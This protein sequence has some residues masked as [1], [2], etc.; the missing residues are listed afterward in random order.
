[1]SHARLRRHTGS[2]FFVLV[3]LGLA[4]CALAPTERGK[5]A[6]PEPSARPAI[7]AKNLVILQS[8]DSPAFAGVSRAIAAKV[9]G[10]VPVFSVRGNP[11]A[12]AKVARQLR[13]RDDQVVVAVGLDAA[14][15]ARKLRGAK[16]VFCQV[17]NYEDFD[18]LTPWMKGVSAV[19]PPERQFQTW[20]KLDPGLKQL[21]VITGPHL[22]DLIAQAKAAAAANG[23]EL[24]HAQ[25]GSDLETLYAFKRL[26]PSIQGLWLLPDNRVLSRD[27]IRD[28][29]SYGRQQ[30]KQIAVF[31]AQLLPFGGTLSFESVYADIAERVIARSRQALQARGPDV[32]GPPVLAL[33]R[34]DFK[35]NPLAVKQL[36]L[37]FPEELKDSAHVP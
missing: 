5:P 36:G 23:I 17:F 21:G 31:A 33:T 2:L 8:D 26:S 1:M 7:D 29:L 4:G 19:P 30:G 24:T 15:V 32:P 18:L 12:E 28:I 35:I 16:V 9:P 11:A 13:R 6:H 3:V 20:K 27:T 37:R 14:L 34:V 25:V 10:N 22:R